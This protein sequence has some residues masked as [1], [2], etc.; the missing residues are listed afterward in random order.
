[1]DLIIQKATELGVSEIL[2][3]VTER[4]IVKGTRKLKRWNTIAE[5][6]AEQCGRSV[7]PSVRVPEELN[8]LFAENKMNGLLF[9][10]KGG[11]G[12]SDAMS[13]I[14]TGK[15]VH[16]FVGPEGGFTADE[17]RKAEEHGI[18]RTTLGKRIFR[19]ETAAIAA[20]ALVQ[21]LLT[22]I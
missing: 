10:E 8:G 16:I 9:W 2:P 22:Q 19:A 6:A 20:T 3:L 7:V 21:Y 11:R 1:M 4:S 17:V 12:L 13:E 14:D 15:A 5:E 18:V